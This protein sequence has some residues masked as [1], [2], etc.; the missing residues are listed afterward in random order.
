MLH[1]D[2]HRRRVAPFVRDQTGA[3][4]KRSTVPRARGAQG[5]RRVQSNDGD[6]PLHGVFQ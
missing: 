1:R 6:D 5:V 2:V 3:I 4:A